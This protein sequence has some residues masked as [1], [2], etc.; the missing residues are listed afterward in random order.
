MHATLG[1]VSGV[2]LILTR[3]RHLLYQHTSLLRLNHWHR[4]WLALGT[5][6]S[7]VGVAQSRILQILTATIADELEKR[8][9]A[10]VQDDEMTTEARVI[11][12]Q[13][14]A[15]HTVHP[16]ET[17]IEETTTIAEIADTHRPRVDTREDI[18]TEIPTMTGRDRPGGDGAYPV[19]APRYRVPEV[20]RR[21]LRDD[22]KSLYLLSQTRSRRT[23][24]RRQAGSL[25]DHPRKRKKKKKKKKNPILLLRVDWLQ[26]VIR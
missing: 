26:R 22:R 14:D 19:L 5:T 8:T 11:T 18:A 7:V 25:L 12:S 23:R 16:A 20:S 2:I 21:I 6:T 24:S 13:K 15:H 4:L 17:D 1:H 10:A 9:T 3:K